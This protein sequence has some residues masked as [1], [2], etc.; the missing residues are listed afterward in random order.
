M[1]HEVFKTIYELMDNAKNFKNDWEAYVHI[2][3]FLYGLLMLKV[4]NREEFYTFRK[5]SQQLFPLWQEH[6]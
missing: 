6:I 3:G 4:I 5:L 2:D 1:D